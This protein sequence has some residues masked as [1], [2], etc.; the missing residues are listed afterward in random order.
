MLLTLVSGPHV[1]IPDM[2]VTTGPLN[3]YGDSGFTTAQWP[4]SPCARTRRP[5]DCLMCMRTLQVNPVCG[6]CSD[7]TAL[8]ETVPCMC[9]VYW[10]HL[11][12]AHLRWP[13]FGSRISA[14][15]FPQGRCLTPLYVLSL[16]LLTT[17]SSAT[18]LP[19]GKIAGLTGPVWPL[20]PLAASCTSISRQFDA[21]KMNR[22]SD[23]TRANI[24]THSQ[25]RQRPSIGKF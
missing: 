11:C 25:V 16:P 20:S 5:D 1:P 4:Q 3:I 6:T 19:D 23:V 8:C 10:G 21:L 9:K 17:R 22:I 2:P 13:M 14:A 7:T 24:F 18:G 15:H 12:Q